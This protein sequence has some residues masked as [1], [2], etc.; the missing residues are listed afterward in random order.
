MTTGENKPKHYVVYPA[1][2]Y[3]LDPQSQQQA[4]QEIRQD[5]AQRVAELNH[6]GKL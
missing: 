2:H 4:L 1:K 6:L 5:T 3:L